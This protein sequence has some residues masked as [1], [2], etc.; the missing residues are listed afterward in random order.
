[1]TKWKDKSAIIIPTGKLARICLHQ[2]LEEA[3]VCPF[4][5]KSAWVNE[6]A[7]AK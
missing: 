4:N 2:H 6:Y 7:N 5:L 1:M 3:N